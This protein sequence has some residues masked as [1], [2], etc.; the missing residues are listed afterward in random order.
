[1]YI[2][3]TSQR[4]AQVL[5]GRANILAV[6]GH[7]EV[8]STWIKG[9]RI[10]KPH[11]A[12]F[13]SFK[14][15]WK[16]W[17]VTLQPPERREESATFADLSKNSSLK[18]DWSG[19]SKGSINGFFT[20]IITMSWWLKHVLSDKAELS[21]FDDVLDDV[22]WVV[23]QAIAALQSRPKR[24]HGDESSNTSTKRYGTRSPLSNVADLAANRCK[25][26]E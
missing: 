7:P 11:I 26:T 25:V 2:Y 15:K 24:P 23:D 6:R 4:R 5:Q 10:A 9:G 22:A 16:K 13:M 1:M 12:D 8:T 18:A 14:S 3:C 20:I 19:L 21:E 17:W